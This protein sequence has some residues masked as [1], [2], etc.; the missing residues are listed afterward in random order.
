MKRITFA[1]SMMAILL[2]TGCNPDIDVNNIDMKAEINTA[3]ALPLGS[4]K[5]TIGDFINDSTTK[6]IY[7]NKEGVLC[8]IDTFPISRPFHDIDLSSYASNLDKTLTVKSKIESLTGSTGNFY[9]GYSLDLIFD[10]LKMDFPNINKDTTIENERLD[11]LVIKNAVF[12]SSVSRNFDLDWSEV[13][14]ISLVLGPQFNRPEGKYIRI[15][16]RGDKKS[17]GSNYDFGDVIPITVDEFTLCLMKN[18]NIDQMTGNRNIN[19]GNVL[20]YCEFAI[21]FYITL[22]GREH[23]ALTTESSFNYHLDLDF[24]DFYSAYGMFRPSSKMRDQDTIDL[25]KEWDT[26]TLFKKAKL[27]LSRP[28]VDM[29]IE[30][31][32]AGYMQMDSLYI[33]TQDASGEKRTAHFN[34]S[35][36][37]PTLKWSS[38]QATGHIATVKSPME[39]YTH[40]TIPFSNQSSEGE[41]DRLFEVK[42]DFIGY[43]FN[44]KVDQD[45]NQQIR[46]TP[47]SDV[48][49]VAIIDAPLDFNEG[50]EL[51]YVD[52]I[53]NVDISAIT[54][55]SL[56]ASGDV[57]DTVKESSLMLVLDIEN[58]IPFQ[59][60]GA[61]RFLG[62]GDTLVMLAN[63]QGLMEPIR[64]SD[65]MG[66]MK[67]TLYIPVPQ[68]GRQDGQ[69]QITAP[70]KYRYVV[71]I[72]Q[73]KF[74]KFSEIKSIQLEAI[75]DNE[76]LKY[77]FKEHPG[78]TTAI[79]TNEQ[80]KVKVGVVLKVDATLDL[81]EDK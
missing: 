23:Q 52:T 35:E 45:A 32:V 51:D 76:A 77:A 40:I 48:K 78:F 13:D 11:S 33:F 53:K 67:D 29:Q 27:P 60:K 6:Y 25:M 1:L 81:N 54:L 46:I 8:F 36:I 18:K 56:L 50:M 75:M 28:H 7:I 69:Y 44:V 55:D 65:E 14:S 59:I 80:L 73:D 10:D 72:S 49:V 68:Y 37:I 2:C 5:M 22:E 38:Y 58:R 74:D 61:F 71:N 20:D 34:G 30:T 9:G 66:E 12:K 70:G 57:L 43:R 16:T 64:V 42:P 31:T 3:L 4:M 47:N 39:D 24:V 62:E 79:A 15:Y 63:E 19:N 41:I 21:N 17:D 26:W